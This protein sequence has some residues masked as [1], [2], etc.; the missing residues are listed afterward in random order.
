MENLRIDGRYYQGC[1]LSHRHQV[2]YPSSDPTNN[3]QLHEY[4]LEITALTNN[5]D[6]YLKQEIILYRPFVKRQIITQ[7]I[8]QPSH[9]RENV[10][11]MHRCY[12]TKHNG[13]YVFLPSSFIISS[14]QML[15]TGYQSCSCSQSSPNV[16]VVLQEWFIDSTRIL[17][18][19]RRGNRHARP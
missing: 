17:H 15:Q 1:A 2:P 3:L 7:N 4:K 19:E 9:T 6:S 13:L 10:D 18:E 12:A 8:V 14:A 16:R 5:N 11:P